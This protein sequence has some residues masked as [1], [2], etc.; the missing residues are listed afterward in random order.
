MPDTIDQHALDELLNC[1]S[2]LLIGVRHHSAALARAMPALLEAY[3]PEVI[4]V[5]LPMEF[6]EWLPWLGDGE[7][8]APVALAGCSESQE[9]LSF[10]PF[11]D[12]SPEL[13]AIRWA[14]QNDVPIEPCD[15]PIATSC[16]QSREHRDCEPNGLLDRIFH[17]TQTRD[18]GTLW[19]RLIE[20]PASTASAESLRR[21]GLLFGY[22]LRC[23]DQ[24]AARFDRFREA[25]MRKCIA[26]K[27]KKCA[28]VVGAYH[29]PALL[30]EPL[31]WSMP[32]EDDIE[33]K[34]TEGKISTALIPYS[35]DQLD[36]RSGYP[37]GIRDPL[38]HQRA[39]EAEQLDD[40]DQT[41]ADLVVA[42][43]RELRE[44]GH[45]MNA[46]DGKEVLRMARDLAALRNFTAPGRGELI[47][48][49]QSCLAR[50]EVMGIGRAV[51]RA[52][53]EVLIGSRQGALPA[54]TPR[55]GLGPYIETVFKTLNLPGPDSPPGEEKR[56][57]LD[58]LRSR[59][60]RARVVTLERLMAAGVPYGKPAETE[61]LAHRENLT[62]VWDVSWT[63]ATAAM[64]ELSA[65]RGATLSQVASGALL[66]A[67][68]NA[69]QDDWAPEQ[70]GPLLQAARCGL[71]ELVR[72]GLDWLMGPFLLTA[73]LSDLTR[74]MEFVERLR[75]GHI[76]GLPSEE[77][78]TY[79]PFVE[80][81][82]VPRTVQTQPLLQAAI[83]QLEGLSGSE[84]MQDASAILDLVLWYQQ[85]TDQGPSVDAGRLIWSLKQL[86]DEGS[87]LMQGA[88]M[89]A[90]LLLDVVD[91]N[92]FGRR[93]GSWIDGAVDGE[94]RKDLQA[95]V[96]GAVY[97]ALP[98]LSSDLSG[99]DVPEQ[100]IAGDT[101]QE[102]LSRLP[103]LRSGFQVLSPAS[104]DRLLKELLD[105]LPEDGSPA[106]AHTLNPEISAARFEADEAGRQATMELMPDISW[107][108][109]LQPTTQRVA[110]D[111]RGKPPASDEAKLLTVQPGQ[112]LS[113]PNR[114]RLILASQP[115]KLPPMAARAAK[116]LDELY[117][118][119]KGEGAR[120]RSR[121]GA[122]QEEAY[123]GTREW[124]EDLGELFGEAVREEVL[125]EAVAAGRA[126]AFA[127]L[128]SEPVKPSIE[129]LEQVLSLK[130]SLP[131]SQMD[132]LR[133]F[134]RKVV[135]QLI[136]E[137]STKLR[138]A[139]SG[140]STPRPTFR[141]TP[142][143]DLNRTVRAN[144]HTARKDKRGNVHLVPERFVF[145][146]LSKRSMDWHVIF[147]VDVS[148]SMEPSVIYSSMM[149][150]IFSG[151]PAIS[152][153]FLAFSTQVIDFT[154]RVEDPLALLME[155]EVGGGTHIAKGL[156]AA[157]ER[158]R[159]PKRSIVLLVTDFEE[160][161]PVSGLLA[162]VRSLIDS[163]A[164]GLGLAALNDD[165]KPRYN[166]GIAGQVVHCGMPVAALS[167]TE[168]ARWVGEQI[169]S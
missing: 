123:P 45:P 102:F 91:A 71:G 147:V 135:D 119:G 137:L 107:E 115:E 164:T 121:G 29:A 114:W 87:P 112:Q 5:E 146:S 132:K 80:V 136:R 38:W 9:D 32:E 154:D 61:D 142:R 27:P 44:Q 60:D 55:S 62:E 84:D 139:L 23:N 88:G 47:E 92:T 63:H 64:V 1:Q 59:L 110:E 98:R 8:M 76:P 74:A 69:P 53:Q 106:L 152:V 89:A 41:V 66:G 37:A 70:L 48:A 50:G 2:P 150:A 39:C 65:A 97:L 86:G 25:H 100:R 34:P 155:I 143:L 51:A 93:F 33:S 68:L 96:Q 46:A 81:F 165:G 75:S 116:A 126:G 169:R 6:A 157:R 148:G 103:A 162:E 73:K 140:L 113:L 128:E 77:S 118:Q 22:A 105:R 124:A 130:G 129:L 90:L 149:A 19:E 111:D 108:D 158:L 134:V 16:R 94:S 144:L 21:S 99:L 56:L 52:M 11:A 159:V 117:G 40:W 168:L 125:G 120:G 160:G 24:I 104:R 85:Q 163:G 153:Q 12:F 72:S 79:P 49:I 4:L 14:F 78:Q 161:W 54:G 43:C 57:R 101:D 3:R 95:R 58:P 145:R 13:A 138:P 18:V 122:G 67:G 166:K 17:R 127:V 7:L 42:V 10:Y 28:A 31:L 20:T 156:K 36:E 109:G 35:F 167:P 30:P 82:D 151:L 131:E 15:L 83:A 141:K 26:E 133:G